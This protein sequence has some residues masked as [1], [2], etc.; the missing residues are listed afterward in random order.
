MSRLVVLTGAGFSRNWGGLLTDEMTLHMASSRYLTPTIKNN[1]LTDDPHNFEKELGKFDFK[2]DSDDQRRLM[3]AL[4]ASLVFHDQLTNVDRSGT[5]NLANFINFLSHCDRSGLPPVW[6]TLNYD[7]LVERK[8]PSKT[9][10]DD[11]ELT[12]PGVRTQPISFPETFSSERH[13]IV[14]PDQ[15][16]LGVPQKGPR[17]ICYYKL[18]GSMNWA[19]GNGAYEYDYIVA[20]DGKVR[21]IQE[22]PLLKLYDEVFEQMLGEHCSVLVIGYSFGDQHINRRLISAGVSLHIIDPQGVR[23]LLRRV[24]AH[25]D[26]GMT[27]LQQVKSIWTRPFPEIFASPKVD[28]RNPI[29]EDL[30]RGL[31]G[32]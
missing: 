27:V 30:V 1:L 28:R 3:Q 11:F 17:Q 26:I 14:L 32:D 9:S 18:H 23:G 21:Q 8:W 29:A 4:H 12:V 16:D 13:R 6:F 31:L 19:T 2:S 25:G 24:R 20:G 5:P 15:V 10:N 7:L 22:R